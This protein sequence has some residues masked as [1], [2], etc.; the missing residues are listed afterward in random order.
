MKAA[1]LV[2]TNDKRRALTRHSPLVTCDCSRVLAAVGVVAGAAYLHHVDLGRVLALLATVLAVLRRGAAA[3]L[4]RALVLTVLV[5][6]L[7][8]NLLL[9]D[10]AVGVLFGPSFIPP[11]R[12]C[13]GGKCRVLRT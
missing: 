11:R 9:D 6:H 10:A 3:G 7:R 8:S 12:K 5:G 13:K 4:T 2:T 1:L